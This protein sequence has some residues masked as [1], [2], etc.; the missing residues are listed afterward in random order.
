MKLQNSNFMIFNKLRYKI[1]LDYSE[2]VLIFLVTPVSIDPVKFYWMFLL[3]IHA[4][5]RYLTSCYVVW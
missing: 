5:L 4:S 1:Q 3:L 2:T